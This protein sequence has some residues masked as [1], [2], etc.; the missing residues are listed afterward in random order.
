VVDCAIDQARARLE[1]PAHPVQG[2]LPV[3][4]LDRSRDSLVRAQRLGA[5]LL[6]GSAGQPLNLVDQAQPDEDERDQLEHP[7]AGR[8]RHRRVQV[9]HDIRALIGWRVRFAVQR[10]LDRHRAVGVD[11]RRRQAGD[12]NFDA[13]PHLGQVGQPHPAPGQIN[14]SHFTDR[15]SARLEHEKPAA[16]PAPHP[17]DLMMLKQPDRLAEHGAAYS[18]PRDQLGLGAHQLTGLKAVVHHLL[19]DAAGDGFGALALG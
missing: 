19:G 13:G 15:G 4:R 11:A 16:R 14:S 9:M 18:F 10:I 6:A 7:V 2:K 5:D 17:C 12:S 1:V 8:G 3:T